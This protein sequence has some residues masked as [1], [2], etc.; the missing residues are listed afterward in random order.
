MNKF[1]NRS[2][3]CALCNVVPFGRKHLILVCPF[4]QRLWSDLLPFLLRIHPGPVTEY[5]MV[6]GLEGNS[7]PIILRN[8]LTFKLRQLVFV[9]AYQATFQP[10]RAHLPLIKF[11][12]NQQ[13]YKELVWKYRYCLHTQTLD[14]FRRQ[15]QWGDHRLV[16]VAHPDIAVAHLF[17]L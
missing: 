4:V 6:F 9:Y 2:E 14:K 12:Y 11:R 5:E 17:P 1:Y 8:W 15:F 7:P 16:T 3:P 13:I 10:R